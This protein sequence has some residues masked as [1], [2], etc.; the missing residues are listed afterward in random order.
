M[1]NRSSRSNQDGVGSPGVNWRFWASSAIVSA[2]VVSAV[3]AIS[4]LF[5][6]T[7]DVILF[8]LLL[9]F[10]R[11]TLQ[12]NVHEEACRVGRNQGAAWKE[13]AEGK[14]QYIRSQS[15]SLSDSE[16]RNTFLRAWI[17]LVPEAKQVTREEILAEVE[18]ELVE[19][20]ARRFARH[21]KE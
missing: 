9:V 3:D 11:M 20:K 15:A 4:R 2:I 18:R 16:S 14:E 7:T 17:R 12:W 21:R 5:A 10:L 13:I 1:N 6:P 19:R 8:I